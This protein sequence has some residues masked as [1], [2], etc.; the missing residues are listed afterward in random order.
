M[1]TAFDLFDEILRVFISKRLHEITLAELYNTITNR[2]IKTTKEEL[3]QTVRSPGF[4]N[5]FNVQLKPNG[6]D[7]IQLSPKVNI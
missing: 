1:A 4:Q 2:K 7:A 6:L 3:L 5:L